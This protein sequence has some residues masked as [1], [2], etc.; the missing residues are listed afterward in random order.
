MILRPKSRPTVLKGTVTRTCLDWQRPSWSSWRARC[1]CE[2]RRIINHFELKVSFKLK[3]Y[4]KEFSGNTLCLSY[5]LSTIS[6]L[7]ST[8]NISPHNCTKQLKLFMHVLRTEKCLSSSFGTIHFA[9]DLFYIYVYYN[10]WFLFSCCFVFQ[11]GTITPVLV[12]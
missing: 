5:V 3:I 7:S 8:D 6:L 9:K 10:C 2:R 11:W 4:V 1:R 12:Q